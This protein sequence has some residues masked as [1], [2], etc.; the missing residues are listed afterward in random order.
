M[1]SKI[2]NTEFTSLC[3]ILII[4]KLL[5]VYPHY[6][7]EAAGGQTWIACLLITAEMLAVEWVLEKSMKAGSGIC[8]VTSKT[9]RVIIGVILSLSFALNAFLTMYPFRDSVSLIL[10][11]E[12]SDE[13]IVLLT[14]A[15]AV[16]GAFCGIAAISRICALYLPIVLTA[17]VIAVL[18]LCPDYDVYN[19]L[20]RE[21]WKDIL[22]SGSASVSMFSDIFAAHSI[23]G[24]TES[25]RGAYK[26]IRRAVIISGITAAVIT[27]G[28]SLR[29]NVWEAWSQL[30]PM[31]Q[32]T[33]LINIGGVL[34][35]MEA[36]FEFAWITDALLY[37]SAYA[38]V[39][40][41]TWAEAFGMRSSRVL[42]LPAA[43]MLWSL[44]SQRMKLYDFAA[45]SPAVYIILFAAELAAFLI[46][47]ALRGERKRGKRM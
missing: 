46:S 19:M 18:L 23:S 22:I 3:V 1:K 47:A 39:I 24:L 17:V 20:P 13:I 29:V 35:R 15:A 12:T 21:E 34:E 2:K 25:P 14:L 16:F 45:F 28:Y 8:S 40:S 32:M 36:L 44:L 11:G 7:L 9:A 5:F 37:I 4:T 31:Y 41:Y 33:R 30:S 10:V 42:I 6:I 43:L 38:A 27:L 26:S